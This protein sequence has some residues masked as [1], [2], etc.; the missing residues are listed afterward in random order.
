MDIKLTTERR[1]DGKID[2]R[3]GWTT[4]GRDWR[5]EGCHHATPRD[6]SDHR[7][8]LFR[9]DTR[10]LSIDVTDAE[11]ESFLDALGLTEEDDHAG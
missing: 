6:A 10:A 11:A 5:P 7:R 8:T 2:F 1:S 4:D 9:T 3:C